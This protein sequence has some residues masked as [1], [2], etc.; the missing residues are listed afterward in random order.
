LVYVLDVNDNVTAS[1]D[2]FGLDDPTPVEL[3]EVMTGVSIADRAVKVELEPDEGDF[4]ES[5]WLIKQAKGLINNVVRWVEDRIK[6]FW[7]EKGFEV[8]ARVDLNVQIDSDNTAIGVELIFRLS[9]NRGG[10]T[11]IRDKSYRFGTIGG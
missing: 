11:I 8:L 4:V 1:V 3:E 2:I 10:I 5:K 7:M 6:R 9:Y